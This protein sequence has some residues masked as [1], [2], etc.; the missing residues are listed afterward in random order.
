MTLP[1]GKIFSNLAS[2][3]PL[4]RVWYSSLSWTLLSISRQLSPPPYV[5]YNQT[6]ALTVVIFW[7]INTTAIYLAILQ[8][9]NNE[10]MELN[11]TPIVSIVSLCPQYGNHTYSTQTKIFY[12]RFAISKI[13]QGI[14][15]L[16]ISNLKCVG[17]TLPIHNHFKVKY[18]HF[19]MYIIYTFGVVS[20]FNTQEIWLSNILYNNHV[21]RG[22]SRDLRLAVLCLEVVQPINIIK[23]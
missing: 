16:E 18:V 6:H 23:V 9:G 21:T 20:A 1:S 19:I 17:I 8:M 3:W 2:I 15:A 22:F 7:A 4:Q 5:V 12:M 11:A 13:M 10:N 14:Y